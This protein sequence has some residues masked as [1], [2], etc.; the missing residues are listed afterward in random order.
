VAYGGYIVTALAHCFEC[1]TPM[2]P[3]GPDMTKLGAG[4]ME[5]ELAPGM[6]VKTANITPDVAT[7]IGSW[8]DADIRKAMTEGIKPD[9]GHISPPM[10]FP[11]FKNMTDQDVDAVIAYLR[12][13][14]AVEN[15]VERTAFQQQAF[16]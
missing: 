14:P 11:F 5:I 12:T 4:G 15:K 10:P 13:I 7:G 6:S 1:H 8:S 3:Q 9:G 2:G 16:P